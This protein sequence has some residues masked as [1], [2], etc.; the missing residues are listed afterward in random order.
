MKRW[1]LALFPLLACLALASGLRA[2]LT[3]YSQNFEGLSGPAALSG[4]GW[5]V[6]GIDHIG[7]YGPF[8][9]PNGG[10]A[11]SSIATGDGGPSQGLQYL[12]VYSDYGN[13]GAH[14]TGNFVNALVFQQQTIGAGDVGK[15]V[16]LSFDYR[17]NPANNNDGPTT[18][19]AFIKVLKQS[20]NSFDELGV[21]E[22]DTTVAPD[23][24]TKSINLAIAA[25]W[26]NELLQFGFRSVATNFNSSGRF[27]DNISFSVGT[28]S[29]TTV[30]VDPGEAWLGFMNVFEINRANN[31]PTPGNYVFGSPWG[32]ADLTASFD[33]N[34][35]LSL[36]VNT[37]GDPN[38]FWYIGGGGPGALGNKWM[39][40]N[41]YVEHTNSPT[42]SGVAVTFEGSVKAN[43]FTNKHTARAF[44]RDFAPD[45]SSF[46]ESS[47][48]LTSGQFSVTLNTIAGAGRH[49]QYGFNVQGENVWVTDA[50]P[51]GKIVVGDNTTPSA[52][53]VARHVYHHNSTFAGIGIPQALD[54]T[55]QLAKASASPLL[56]DFVNVTNSSRGINGIA[57]DIQDLAGTP[58]ASDFEF[59][60][61]PTGAF[62]SG[63]N[64]PS[65]WSSAPAP[66]S[67]AVVPGTPDRVVITWT[68][69]AVANRWL[70]VTVKANSNTGIAAPEIYYV[71]HL[72]GE[73]TG[74][75]GTVYT[76]AFADISPI[77]SAVGNTVDAGSIVDIDKNGTVA[78]AD[79]TAMRA[80]VGAQL[81]NITIPAA[82]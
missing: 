22:W 45:Y 9:A 15:T 80:N 69:N 46:Q 51:F 62:D 68:D 82:P 59:R 25:G 61:S 67:V 27:Y 21:I 49:V 66:A 79:I 36:G 77:R 12:N 78:F 48:L 39:D 16:T 29:G 81:S 70:Q 24:Q 2:D 41:S 14:G 30:T 58:T 55:K 7:S 18:T 47:V 31:P 60:M 6:F 57:F 63:A 1:F 20:D 73:T 72:L 35:C 44:I 50:A 26:A 11:F 53:I 34:G 38:P 19:F 23:W 75:S 76:V 4:N 13:S 37:I 3:T 5:L 65:G 43:T 33:G 74:L 8:P 64:P 42:Y 71:G 40:A 17:A 32:F 10:Q 56:L 52:T 54:T 28:P